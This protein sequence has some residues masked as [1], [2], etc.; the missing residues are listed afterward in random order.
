MKKAAKTLCVAI[1][2]LVILSAST[3]AQ[4]SPSFYNGTCRDVSHVVWKVVSQAVGSEKRMAASLLRLHF[5]DCFVNGCDGSVLLDDTASFTGEKSAGPN[6]NSLRGFE[7]IDAIKSQLESQCPGIVSCADIV[8]LAA[9][10]SVFM[11]GGPGWAVPLGRRDST[12]ASRDAANS[13]I[14]PPVFTVSEL[15]SAFQAKGL[16]LKDMVVLSGAHT[17]GAAQCFT[18]RN[19]LY[20][21]NSTAAS[22]PTIDASFLATLQ[23]SCPKESGD[24]QLSNLDAVTPNRFDNQYYKNLQK[25]KGLLTSDQEL[26]SGTGSDAATLVSSYASNPLTFWRDF[27]ESM[28]KMGNISPLTGTNGEIRKNCHFVNS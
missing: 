23:S 26:F 5:H 16:S 10:T 20:S 25:N 27:K 4:L 14:P 7:V 9:Q 3:C 28:I 1:A 11:L 19:R 24:D 15:T 17:I 22:D 13:Q 8:A 18:F 12:T 6:K 21:F 2:S